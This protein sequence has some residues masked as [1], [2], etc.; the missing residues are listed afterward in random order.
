MKHLLVF[1]IIFS[2]TFSYGQNEQYSL[3]LDKKADVQDIV[4]IGDQGFLI[5]TA[6]TYAKKERNVQIHSF[7]ADLK[8]RWTVKLDK[9]TNKFLNYTLLASPYSPMVYYIETVSGNDYAKQGINITRIDSLGKKSEIKYDYSKDFKRADRVAMFADEEALYI[10]NSEVTVATDKDIKKKKVANKKESVLVF[11]VM[12]NSKK[13]MERFVTDIK[14]TSDDKDADLFV[15]YLGHDED[16]IFLSR[17]SLDLSQN[18]I[19]YEVIT[20]DKSFNNVDV[21]NFE[22]TLENPLV[23][24]LNSRAE[25]GASIYNNDYDVTVVQRGN[26]ITTTYYANAGS[27]GCAQLDVLNGHFYIYGLTGAKSTGKDTKKEKGS[28]KMLTKAEG[29]YICKFDFN[30]GDE[31][32]RTEF[33]LGKTFTADNSFS[34]PY[35]FTARSIWLDVL[36]ED[37]YKFCGLSGSIDLHA[38]VVSKQEKAEYI[39]MKLED[40]GSSSDLH[41]KSIINLLGSRTYFSNNHL[42]FMKDYKE[43]RT[44][45]YSMFGILLGDRTVVIKNTAYT[46][47]PKLE[48][49]LFRHKD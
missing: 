38:I 39:G 48:F 47:N 1:L 45:E 34:D 36:S 44:K 14:L 32:S 33:K 2:G 31:K 20:L 22:V 4:T 29:G 43:F 18:K 5:K 15:E 12:K 8:K 9:P 27:F 21:T 13:V 17:K 24:A 49:N 40:V 28:G 41:R 35:L 37:T 11:Y 23:P 25:N 19:A 30:T 3:D 46:E 7:S 6:I 10:L 26:T 16:N 42:D